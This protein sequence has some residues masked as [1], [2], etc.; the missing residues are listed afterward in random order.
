MTFRGRPIQGRKL[1]CRT[2]VFRHSPSIVRDSQ[3]SNVPCFAWS[4]TLKLSEVVQEK[5][6]QEKALVIFPGLSSRGSDTGLR[7][8]KVV[9]SYFLSGERS[10]EVVSSVGKVLST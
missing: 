2:D 7:R 8:V 6:V 3:C 10:I 5:A 1:Y 9:H 4:G